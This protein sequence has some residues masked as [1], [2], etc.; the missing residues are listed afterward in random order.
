AGL[1]YYHI[2]QDAYTDDLGQYVSGINEDIL[3]AVAGVRIGKDF[4]RFHPEMYVGLTYDLVKDSNDTHV[5]LSNGGH[6]VVPG[7]RLPRLGYEFNADV[8][9]DLTD[10]ITVGVGYMG[11]YRNNYQEHTGM[12]M[13]RYSF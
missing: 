3:R 6:Y 11:A 8:N 5:G 2:K 7:K 10:N 12:I 1:R 4:S 13:F 9:A